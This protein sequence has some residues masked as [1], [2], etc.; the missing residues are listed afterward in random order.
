MGEGYRKNVGLER[1]LGPPRVDLL[2]SKH[3]GRGVGKQPALHF[4]FPVSSLVK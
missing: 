1:D 2:S 4:R 3:S